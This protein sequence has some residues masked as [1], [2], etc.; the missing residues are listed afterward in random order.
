MTTSYFE[1][2]EKLLDETG[3]NLL[4]ELQQDAR[5]SYAELGRRVGLSSPAVMERVK[6][7]EEAGI[8]SGYH[9]HINL[10]KIGVELIAFVRVSNSN[11]H[12]AAIE[13]MAKTMPEVLECH[14]VLGD[15][16]FILKVAVP[17]VKDLERTLGKF[18]HFAGTTTTTSL[19][20]SSPVPHRCIEPEITGETFE[21]P[22]LAN[23][24]HTNG[25][26]NHRK[27]W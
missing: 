15:D 6:R 12:G 13:A 19:V 2:P 4:R 25:N 17:G 26:S 7:L 1:S 10:P 18:S 27:V 14:H 21:A 22:V 24:N 16:C 23:G 11:N 8:I 5:M 3:W 20:L 9:A